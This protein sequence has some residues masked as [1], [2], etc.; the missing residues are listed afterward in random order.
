MSLPVRGAWIEIP[1]SMKNPDDKYCRSPCGERGLKSLDTLVGRDENASLPVRGAWIEMEQ[2][3]HMLGLIV[4][5]PVRG[6]W[7]EMTID[8]ISTLLKA[9]RSP[10]GE[11]GLKYFLRVGH[12]LPVMSLP[13]RGAWIEIHAAEGDSAKRKVAPRAG[14]VD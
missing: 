12:N 9:G 13:V 3:G 10:C 5:L 7:I 1:S 4:S 6:A 2:M 8:K 14:S 11:R